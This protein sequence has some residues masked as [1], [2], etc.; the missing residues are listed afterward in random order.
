MFKKLSCFALE[1]KLTNGLLK[2]TRP[3][4]L[5]PVAG[6]KNFQPPPDYSSVELPERP[7]LRFVEKV[8][9]YPPTIR[10]PKMQRRLD[11]IR[12]PEPYLTEL[13][14]KQ[15]GIISLCGGLLRHGHFE[16]MRMTIHRKM[17]ASKMFAIWRVDAPWKPVTRKGQGKRMG[18]GKGSIDHYV[19]P[20]KAG[21][22]IMEVG[23][24]CE[25]AEVKP[26][27]EEMAHKLPFPAKAV[28]QEILEQDTAEE[29][30]L[31]E[32]N[33]NPYTA[34]YV[35]LNNMGGC[36]SWISPYDKKWFWKHV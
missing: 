22:V 13:T 18:G 1:S 28:S 9:Q 31:K 26:F 4:S 11:L 17:D 25:F 29:K 23:G 12:G 19:T 20:V 6:L 33:L 21:R 16:M 32:T 10:P 7:K 36:H 27:L 15:Y 8:P 5:T 14:L 34:E 2:Q 35:I 30:R 3:I 24:K